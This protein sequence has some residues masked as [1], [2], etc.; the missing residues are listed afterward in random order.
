MQN[1]QLVQRQYVDVLL[2]FVDG[3]EVSRDVE[4]CS[5]PGEAGLVYDGERRNG[6]YTASGS[7][8]RFDFRGQELPDRLHAPKESGR[9][10]RAKTNAIVGDGELVTFLAERRPW[11]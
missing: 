6:P 9:C 10:C 8:I 4:H 5:T 7:H 2:H 3:E 11:T 1:V